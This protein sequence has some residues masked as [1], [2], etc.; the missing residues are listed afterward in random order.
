MPKQHPNMAEKL[1][2][3]VPKWGQV[4]LQNRLKS[5]KIDTENHTENDTEKTNEK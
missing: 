1:P 5:E 2:N 3:M 4:G